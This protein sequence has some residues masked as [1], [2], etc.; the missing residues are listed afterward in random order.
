MQQLKG[1]G[2]RFVKRHVRS[3]NE[4][5]SDYDVVVNAAGL[6]GGQV[7]GDVGKNDVFPIRGILFE[8]DAP[9]QKLFHWE[10]LETYTVPVIDSVY[11]GTVRQDNNTNTVIT[12]ADRKGILQ[13]YYRLQPAMKDAKIKS[14]WLGFRPGRYAV[15]HELVK[16]GGKRIIHN[17]GHG[18]NGFTLS[19]GCALDVVRKAY[20]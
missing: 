1:Y 6:N 8:I 5:I 2:A 12:D 4:L 11:L 19:W 3:V 14:E 13:R 20:Q 17:Y 7:A 10:D 16:S 18:G 9:W 15:R